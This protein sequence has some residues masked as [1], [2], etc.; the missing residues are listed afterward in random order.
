MPDDVIPQLSL[1]ELCFAWPSG[2]MHAA[3]VYGAQQVKCLWHLNSM[4]TRI[5]EPVLGPCINYQKSRLIICRQPLITEPLDSQ[6]DATA[7]FRWSK[8]LS[9]EVVLEYIAKQGIEDELKRPSSFRSVM[10][11]KLGDYIRDCVTLRE[12]KVMGGD[13][14]INIRELL[15]TPISVNEQ[16]IQTP[17]YRV[18]T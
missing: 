5:T 17:I 9:R 3:V 10:E 12:M 14:I 18:A 8:G 13:R 2:E 16:L 1:D 4:L 15:L 6:P 11:A 7:H